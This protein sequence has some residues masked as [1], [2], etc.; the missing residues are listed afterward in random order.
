MMPNDQGPAVDMG[1]RSF[2]QNFSL[3]MCIMNVLVSVVASVIVICVV[4]QGKRLSK[5]F[6]R[7]LFILS[8][9][10]LTIGLFN[11]PF[12]LQEEF[13]GNHWSHYPNMMCPTIRFIQHA[14]YTVS[15]YT[16]LAIAVVRRKAALSSHLYS[17]D[18]VRKFPVII[19]NTPVIYATDSLLSWAKIRARYRRLNWG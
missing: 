5:D 17:N 9:A 13:I 3:A 11:Y 10:S 18:R 7:L 15:I 2:F 8:I 16:E 4:T 12:T 14:S 19:L 6:R 1:T